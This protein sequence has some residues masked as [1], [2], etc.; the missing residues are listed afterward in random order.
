MLINEQNT[1]VQFLN[2]VLNI[3]KYSSRKNKSNFKKLNIFNKKDSN[4][5]FEQEVKLFH[6]TI[7][8]TDFSTITSTDYTNTKSIEQSA[9]KGTMSGGEMIVH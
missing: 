1:S 8:L 9:V 4:F 7:Y 2:K 5:W 6:L 3:L